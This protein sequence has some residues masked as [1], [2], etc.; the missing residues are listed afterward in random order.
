MGVTGTADLATQALNLRMTAVL[1]KAFTD[2]LGGA[3][4]IGGFMNT[5]LANNQGELVIPATVTGTGQNPKFAPDLK[6]IGQMKLK[7]LLPNS[8]NPSSAVS[9]ILGGLLGRKA[10]RKL[11]NSHSN[12]GH[13]TPSI[14]SSVFSARKTSGHNH[15][16]SRLPHRRPPS[17]AP[18]ACPRASPPGPPD[19]PTARQNSQ[20]CKREQSRPLLRAASGLSRRERAYAALPA[21][22]FGEAAGKANGEGCASPTGVT[23]PALLAANKP[24]LTELAAGAR[25]SREVVG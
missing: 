4:G 13:R 20:R 3:A 24:P 10:P 5:A 16:R 25:T 2:K 9:G 17:S 1:S 14:K 19:A 23:A 11:N 15:S 7:G 22:V 18:G 8:N 21:L 6:Q 12:S